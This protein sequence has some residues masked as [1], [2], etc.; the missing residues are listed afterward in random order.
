MIDLIEPYYNINKIWYDTWYVFPTM[1]S[2]RFFEFLK[3]AHTVI[4]GIMVNYLNYNEI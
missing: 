3:I 4:Q 1:V 2:Q